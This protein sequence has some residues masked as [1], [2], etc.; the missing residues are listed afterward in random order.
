GTFRGTENTA[1]MVG[2][3]GYPGFVDNFRWECQ[4]LRDIRGPCRSEDYP[5]DVFPDEGGILPLALDECDV[6][7]CWVAR[8]RTEDWPIFVRW[9]WGLEGM[10]IFEMPLSKLLVSLFEREIELPCFPLPTFIDDVRFVP[11]V[12]GMTI[13]GDP[14]QW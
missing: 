8:R 1:L 7:L 9:T 11:Y 14:I 2:C 5:F 4:R 6:W 12:K 3:P 13:G 10:K